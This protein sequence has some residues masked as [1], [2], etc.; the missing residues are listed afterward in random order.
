MMRF[1]FYDFV[2]KKTYENILIGAHVTPLGPSSQ[3][4]VTRNIKFKWWRFTACV[5]V[6]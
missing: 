3:P 4:T 2:A 5:T 6:T 1:E